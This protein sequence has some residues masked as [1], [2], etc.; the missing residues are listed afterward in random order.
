[1]DSV[2]QFP[3]LRLSPLV[4]NPKN[5]EN[6][7]NPNSSSGMNVSPVL[8]FNSDLAYAGVISSP[9]GPSQELGKPKWVDVAAPTSVPS[10]SSRMNLSYY[11]PHVR[12]SKV[13]VCP[14]QDVVD[15][16]SDLWTGCV[17]G[18]FLDKKAPFPLVKSIV[19]RIWEKFGIYEVLANDQG[20]FF[21]KFSKADACTVMEAGPWHVAGKLLILKPWE[22]QMVF[23]KE[24]LSTIPVWVQFSHIPLEFW[25]EQGLSYIASALGKPLY[26]D[27]M[28]EKGKRLSF[29]KICVEIHVDTSLL[30][31]VEVE[32]ANGASAFI[33]VKYPWKPSRCSACHVFGHTEASH[34]VQQPAA[35]RPT[36]TVLASD[37][38]PIGQAVNLPS[39]ETVAQAMMNSAGP[40]LNA[41]GSPVLDSFQQAFEL[42]FVG[43]SPAKIGV[44]SSLDL[45][46][47]PLTLLQEDNSFSMSKS[48]K[49]SG[50]KGSNGLGSPPHGE[51]QIGNTFSILESTVPLDLSDVSIGLDSDSI[52]L[53]LSVG[54]VPKNG[55]SGHVD[56]AVASSVANGVVTLVLPTALVEPMVEPV[57]GVVSGQVEGSFAQP[58]FVSVA[59]KAGKGRNRGAS[60]KRYAVLSH[61]SNA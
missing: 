11:H 5:G 47:S 30:D 22:P 16:G 15:L 24:K 56:P 50:K 59:A 1:M 38:L 35:G 36:A 26:A 37:L 60:K 10:D 39:E 61:F 40:L 57:A 29:A 20:F 33:H 3:L 12:D 48:K 28:T 32:Y 23:T 54:V 17:V 7:Q 13:V 46:K 52:V 41:L 9:M 51:V 21:F 53:P 27:D 8:P 55:G 14:P 58:V 43:A 49:N 31:V 34:K 44:G 18:Y 45:S 42:P 2:D 6:S 19:T 4:K 25:A